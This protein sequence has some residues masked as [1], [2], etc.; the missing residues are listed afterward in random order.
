MK[1]TSVAA[2]GVAAGAAAFATYALAIR[3]WHLRWGA[4]DEEIARTL[5]LDDRVER[6]DYVTN[7]AITIHAGPRDVWPWLVQMGELPRGGFYSYEWIERLMG[8]RVAN[9]ESVLPWFQ[10]LN[11]GQPLDRKAE[12]IVKAVETD[13]FLVL[14]PPDGLPDMAVTWALVLFPG[15]N[16]DTRLVSRVRARLPRGPRGWFWFALLD[17]GQF[18]MERKMLLYI[19]R[20]AEALAAAA[21]AAGLAS[22]GAA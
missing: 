20:R 19:K 12:M 2:G 9:A 7:R 11:V 3:P 18:V 4:T 5:A 10:R 14:G 16:G 17:P 1:R 15:Q 13:R 21:A 6:P 22:I 8:M